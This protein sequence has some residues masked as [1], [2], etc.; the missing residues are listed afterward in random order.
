MSD[1]KMEIKMNMGIPK[2]ADAS[3]PLEQIMTKIREDSK[4]NIRKQRSPH[5]LGGRF[6]P[7]A[8]ETIKKKIRKG[9]ERSEMALYARGTMFRNIVW[10]KIAKNRYVITVRGVGVPR[11]DLVARIHQ[12]IGVPTK[13]G[14]VVRPFLGLSPKH[15]KYAVNR[16]RRWIR[17]QLKETPPKWIKIGLT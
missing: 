6:R 17:K 1:F 3:I 9:Y 2:I 13:S 7:L 5:G 10:R 12:E 8:E 4:Q 16:M 14:R 15:R 11:R